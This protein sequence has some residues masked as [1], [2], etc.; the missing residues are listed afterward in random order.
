MGIRNRQIGWS[1]KS[2]M[3]YNILRELRL[4]NG[5]VGGNAST[6]TTTTTIA[7]KTY[8][9]LAD[10]SVGLSYTY[11]AC[12]GS[13][14]SGSLASGSGGVVICA[15]SVSYT[16]T[17]YDLNNND[18]R[19]T[20]ILYELTNN[21][22]LDEGVDYTDCSGNS[23]SVTVTGNSIAYICAIKDSVVISNVLIA[24]VGNCECIEYQ[25]TAGATSGT[26]RYIGCDY[27]RSGVITLN[28]GTTIT[29][30]ALDVPRVSDLTIAVVGACNP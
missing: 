6:T 7:C 19:S 8:I 24:P 12:N 29:I 23:A 22:L 14:E 3:L 4:L 27:V 20:C 5:Q 11:T 16:G 30:C 1:D 21:T 9:L 13:S 17:K 26:Y 2:N 15:R 18:C 28:A 25:L 10:E